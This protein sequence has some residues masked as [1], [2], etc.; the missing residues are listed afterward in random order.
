M[1]VVWA[2]DEIC[3]IGHRY[4]FGLAATHPNTNSRSPHATR[5]DHSTG[6]LGPKPSLASP[7]FAVA[8][9]AGERLLS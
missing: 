1:E 6:L 7:W 3:D 5:T 2:H 8:G 9:R 4:V